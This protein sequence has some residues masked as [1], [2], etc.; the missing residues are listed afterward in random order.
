MSAQTI[1]KE[2]ISTILDKVDDFYIC[3]ATKYLYLKD[4][5]LGE[6]ADINTFLVV[7]W[8]DRILTSGICLDKSEDKIIQQLNL[9]LIK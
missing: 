7:E 1:I 6:G 3:E 4:Y 5:D 9:I 2:N 8:L